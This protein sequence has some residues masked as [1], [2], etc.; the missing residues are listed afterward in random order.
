MRRVRER[1]RSAGR[2][3]LR[4]ETDGYQLISASRYGLR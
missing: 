2:V 1:V 3:V 4:A